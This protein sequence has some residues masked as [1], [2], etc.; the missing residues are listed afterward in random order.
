MALFLLIHILRH[1][2]E[3]NNKRE[4]KNQKTTTGGST[5]V[6]LKP[7]IYVM[8]IQ[9]TLHFFF[10]SQTRMIEQKIPC[11]YANLIYLRSN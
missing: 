8:P 6:I 11:I 4:T 1:R 5:E 9:S 10:L 2:K 3:R 7:I